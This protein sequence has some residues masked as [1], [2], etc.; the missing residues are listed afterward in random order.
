MTYWS[1]FCAI[2]CHPL[3]L[4][5]SVSFLVFSDLQYRYGDQTARDIHA[6]LTNFKSLKVEDAKQF[7]MSAYCHCTLLKNFKVSPLSLFPPLSS[8][9]PPSP[10]SPPPPS[11]LAVHPNG[12]T[13]NM[14]SVSGTIP[15][16][17][18]GEN[19]LV[20][21]QLLSLY[22]RCISSLLPFRLPLFL[23]STSLFLPLPLPPPL[24]A[25]LLLS[26]PLFHLIPFISLS[27]PRCMT[28]WLS[29]TRNCVTSFE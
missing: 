12:T 16:K 17:I 13:E 9:L 27:F 18:R 25:H 6:L 19:G 7:G 10:S 8:R 5:G 22:Y 23:L 2:T 3:C 26:L 21:S 4:H 11:S 1:I 29:C 15:V 24:T 14:V 20:P 28:S